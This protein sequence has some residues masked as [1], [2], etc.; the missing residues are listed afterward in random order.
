MTLSCI[1]LLLV[2][3]LKKVRLIQCHTLVKCLP[4]S[5]NF[6]LIFSSCQ[7][8]RYVLDKSAF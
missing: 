1:A 3:S 8:S 5:V 2:S 6:A 4:S 7:K